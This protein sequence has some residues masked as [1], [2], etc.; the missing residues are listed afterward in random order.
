MRGKCEIGSFIS[1]Y[2]SGTYSRCAR[3][4]GY[5]IFKWCAVERGRYAPW[6]F[7]TARKKKNGFL[8]LIS[9]FFHNFAPENEDTEEKD[10]IG[11]ASV[12]GIR[13]DDDAY[14]TP[15]PSAGRQRCRLRGMHPP[16]AAPQPLDGRCRTHA[17]LR[18]VPVPQP[19]LSAGN[20]HCRS[21][22]RRRHLHCPP[23]PLLFHRR[24][25]RQCPV[26]KGTAR[27][28]FCLIAAEQY[29][30]MNDSS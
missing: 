2:K 3:C 11:V 17:R 8:L 15:P 24:Q 16:R 30:I 4:A 7:P 6:G 9:R 12:V 5:I 25:R 28:L 19:T 22:V 10:S 13:I 23:A 1:A 18:A 21:A 14:R 20:G 29:K 26:L 27:W